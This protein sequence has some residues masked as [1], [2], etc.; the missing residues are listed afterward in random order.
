MNW[1]LLL[2]NFF[3]SFFD[4][5]KPTSSNR[6]FAFI[7][8]LLLSVGIIH[9]WFKC[10]DWNLHT[11]VILYCM[12]FVLLLVSIIKVSDIAAL[13]TGVTVR[14]TQVVTP[15]GQSQEISKTVTEPEDPNSN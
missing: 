2:A 15:E 5:S 8:I 7:V 1:I 6:F 9:F 14:Q 11:S 12:A 10:P 13:R 4:Q 3:A